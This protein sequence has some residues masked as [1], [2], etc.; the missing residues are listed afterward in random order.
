MENLEL[1]K[2]R[3]SVRQF[4]EEK[5]KDEDKI[6]LKELVQKLNKEHKLNMQIFFDE[7]SAFSTSMAHYGRF[8]NCNNYIALVGQKNDGEALGFYG[9]EILLKIYELGMAGCWVALTYGKGKVK[10][11]KEKG[12]VLHLVIGFGYGKNKGNP[13]KLKTPDQIIKKGSVVPEYAKVGIEACLLAPTAM[14]QQKFEISFINNEPIINIKGFGFNTN[15]DLGIL[16]YHFEL[17][18]GHK[19]N[20]NY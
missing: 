6:T 12:E 10:I 18:T 15:I 14:N 7:P 2:N 4:T 17:V 11:A 9:E 19:T 8:E 3:H 5:V 13:H 20:R 16:K 1:L